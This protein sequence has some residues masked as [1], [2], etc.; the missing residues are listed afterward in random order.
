MMI[1]ILPRN[2]LLS[3]IFGKLLYLFGPDRYRARAHL[4]RSPIYIF[5]VYNDCNFTKTGPNFLSFWWFQNLAVHT[6]TYM[7]DDQP[8]LIDFTM[9]S[10][11]HNWSL[12][13]I[14]RR[15]TAFPDHVSG[16]EGKWRKLHGKY[17]VPL[18]AKERGSL[19]LQL[20]SGLGPV[21]QNRFFN[22]KWQK[23][24]TNLL[25]TNQKQVFQ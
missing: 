7:L 18:T 22:D 6:N 23:S 19:P 3:N 17:R 8:F 5:S 21:S 12:S 20:T 14:I 24:V 15:S 16:L 4:S 2:R 10:H 25:I 9:Q 11:D 13:L 1:Q